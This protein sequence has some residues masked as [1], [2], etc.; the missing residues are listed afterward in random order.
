MVSLPVIRQEAGFRR[1]TCGCQLCSCYCKVMPGYLVPADLV[2]LIPKDTDP[3]DWARTHLRASNGSVLVNTL[4]GE[5]INI[6]SLVPIK[7]ANGHCHW[8]AT[9]GRC[10]V[11][12]DSPF[13]C[14][15][16]DQHMKDDEAER[17]NRYA[18]LSRAQAFDDHSLYAQIWQM[19]KSE[20]LIGGGEYAQSRRELQRVR[21]S[22]ERQK[23]LADK[24]VRRRT[25]KRERQN[26][27]GGK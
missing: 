20:G 13:G 27:C 2:R 15:F 1:T 25:K 14:A 8:L 24:S 26:R 18:R 9:N 10:T 11:H 12:A 22:I 21:A 4:T 23:R 16:F 7:K 19:L 6:P 17:R 3:M 5:S